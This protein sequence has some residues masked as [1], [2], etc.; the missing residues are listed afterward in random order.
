M[1]GDP[2]YRAHNAARAREWHAKNPERSRALKRKDATGWTQEMFNAAW[3]KQCGCC[4]I[5]RRKLEKSGKQTHADHDHETKKPR[6]IL[7]HGCNTGIGNLG[8]SPERLEAAAAY[9]RSFR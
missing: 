8:D 1:K 9:I 2:E 7:C 4:A 3:E 5:C 6:A